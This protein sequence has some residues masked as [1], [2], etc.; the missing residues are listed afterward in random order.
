MRER[1]LPFDDPPK[2]QRQRRRLFL[3]GPI[4]WVWLTKVARLRKRPWRTALLLLLLR[5]LQSGRV[6]KI[7]YARARDLGLHRSTVYRDLRVLETAGLI[8]VDRASGR[9]PRVTILEAE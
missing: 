3:Y 2:R 8:E 9:S 6:V 4:D 7:E 5:G 1:E